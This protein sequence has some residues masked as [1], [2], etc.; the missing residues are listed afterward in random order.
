MLEALTTDVRLVRR[1]ADVDRYE[2]I[3]RALLARG[4]WRRSEADH[5]W[6][7]GARRRVHG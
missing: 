1:P 2:R 7:P 4:R 6:W 3:D 5:R